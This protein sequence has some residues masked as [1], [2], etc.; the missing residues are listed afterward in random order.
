MVI[1]LNFTVGLAPKF[2]LCGGCGGQKDETKAALLGRLLRKSID[3]TDR[4]QVEP[5]IPKTSGDHIHGFVSKW[6]A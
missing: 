4:D 6:R 3:N 2:V 1:Q 5:A